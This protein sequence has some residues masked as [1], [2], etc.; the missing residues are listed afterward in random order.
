MLQARPPTRL[1]AVAG[2]KGQLQTDT[3]EQVAL[4]QHTQY[5]TQLTAVT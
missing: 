2:T 1:K 4:T 3:D 5:T